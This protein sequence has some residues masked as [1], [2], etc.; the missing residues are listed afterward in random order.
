MTTNN[1]ANYACHWKA[2]TKCE[3]FNLEDLTSPTDLSFFS[4]GA[5]N[6]RALSGFVI[7]KL[8]IFQTFDLKTK[9]VNQI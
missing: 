5:L 1:N 7:F 3:L 9:S 2:Y 8:L 4:C 6:V